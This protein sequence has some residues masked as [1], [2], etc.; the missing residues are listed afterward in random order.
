MHTVSDPAHSFADVLIHE[1]ET[2]RTARAAREVIQAPP[3][4]PVAA[5]PSGMQLSLPASVQPGPTP[6][7]KKSFGIKSKI[8]DF[9]T[10]RIAPSI[11]EFLAVGLRFREKVV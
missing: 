3:P 1:L 6:A 5:P 2:I 7:Q 10:D 8:A 11:R 4:Q 9:V